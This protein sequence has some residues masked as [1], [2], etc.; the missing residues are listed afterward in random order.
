MGRRIGWTI[1]VLGTLAALYFVYQ[2]NVEY[3]S[4][5][6][7]VRVAVAERES[8]AE[9]ITAP[10]EVVAEVR[11]DVVATSGGRVIEVR[12]GAGATVAAGDVVVVF[13]EAPRRLELQQAEA[14]YLSAQAD[15]EHWN[16]FTET[17]EYLEAR[18]RLDQDRLAV[19]QAAAQLESQRR[20]FELGAIPKAALDE[21]AAAFDQA[22]QRLALSQQ[23]FDTLTKVTQP[24]ELNRAE[25]ALEAAELRLEMAREALA[26]VEVKAPISGVITDMRASAGTVVGAGAVLFTVAD[27]SKTRVEAAVPAARIGGVDIGQPVTIES[28]G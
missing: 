14:A 6:P 11:Q 21:A 27:L 5:F 22:K 28:R 23:A 24:A 19:E 13:D 17:Q 4:H 20:L 9:T 10:G 15:F 12:A 25:R 7:R 26:A 16:A 3:F 2:Y 8:L 1:F 18:T